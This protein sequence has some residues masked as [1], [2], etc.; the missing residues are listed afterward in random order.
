MAENEVDGDSGAV[1]VEL[2]EVS[3]WLSLFKRDEGEEGISGEGQIECCPRSS[4]P[5][6]I[7]L[8]R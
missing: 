2:E 6:T 5:V 1:L 8:P 3:K 4:M 7:L